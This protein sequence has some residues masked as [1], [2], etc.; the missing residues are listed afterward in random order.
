MH[1]DIRRSRFSTNLI[2]TTTGSAKA[3]GLIFPELEGKL[4]GMIRVPVLNASLTDCV[5]K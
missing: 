5:V 1:N 4:D 2:P 3:I